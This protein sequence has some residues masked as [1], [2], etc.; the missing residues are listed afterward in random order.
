[1][2][3]EQEEMLTWL[4]LSEG[5]G[6]KGGTATVEVLGPD[7]LGILERVHEWRQIP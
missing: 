1:M 2:P 7:G 6:F 5:A 3:L 4:V